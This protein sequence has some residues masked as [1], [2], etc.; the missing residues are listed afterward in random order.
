ME[1]RTVEEVLDQTENRLL[2]VRRD[3]IRE[4]VKGYL[5]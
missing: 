5:S 1:G 2:K 4:V 3:E